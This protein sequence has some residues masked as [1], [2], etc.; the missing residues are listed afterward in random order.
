MKSETNKI[1][2]DKMLKFACRYL[3]NFLLNSEKLETLLLKI[4]L[5]KEIVGMSTENI[6]ETP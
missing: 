1:K 5:E 4:I 6:F 3:F 2:S